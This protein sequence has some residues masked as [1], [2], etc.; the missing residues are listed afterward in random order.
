MSRY[1]ARLGAPPMGASQGV[2]SLA[3]LGTRP[4]RCIVLCWD[5]WLCCLVLP[6]ALVVCVCGGGGVQK[7]RKKLDARQGPCRTSAS[8]PHPFRYSTPVL[9]GLAKHHGMF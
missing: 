8:P 4:G 9:S 1:A 7:G 3:A 5:L 2:V 6:A